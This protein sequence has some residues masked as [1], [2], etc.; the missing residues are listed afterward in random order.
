[1]LV[2]SAEGTKPS[3]RRLTL[4]QL[5][6]ALRAA[7]GYAGE[8]SVVEELFSE[9]D[10]DEESSACLDEFLNWLNGVKGRRRVARS[11]QLSNRAEDEPSLDEIDWSVDT[12]RQELN[13]MLMKANCSSYDLLMAYDKSEDGGEWSFKSSPCHY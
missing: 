3:A 1:M 2:A 9:M 8:V 11:L 10:D 13:S 12:L 6:G 7:V 5:T 4:P